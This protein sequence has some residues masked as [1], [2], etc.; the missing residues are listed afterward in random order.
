MN[1]KT[2]LLLPFI[3]IFSC[4]L[5]GQESWSLDQCIQHALKNNIQ[6]QQLDFNKEISRIDF[7]QSKRDVLPNL[8]GSARYGYNFGRSI[9]PTTYN[10]STESITTN[11]LSLNSNFNLFNGFQ[12]KNAIK[13][14]EMQYELADINKKATEEDISL[15]VFSAYLAILQTTEQLK[16]LN[17]QIKLSQDRLTQMEKMVKAGVMPKGDLYDIESQIANEE[18]NITNAENSLQQGYLN[19]YQLI[20][21]TDDGFLIE[22][23]DVE[24]P[25]AEEVQNLSS[26]AI[27]TSSLGIRP[28][29]KAAELQ[30]QIADQQIEIAEGAKYPNV[31]LNGTIGT[32]GSSLGVRNIGTETV[33]VPLF[34]LDGQTVFVPQTVPIFEDANVIQQ[35]SDNLNAYI[36]INVSVPIFNNG[37]VNSNVKRAEINAQNARLSGQIA[38]N[39]LRKEVEDAYY[40]LIA[41]AK[42]YEAAQTNVTALQNAYQQ[43]E[44]KFNL[45]VVNAFEYNSAKDRLAIGELNLQSAKYN[46]VFRLNILRFYKGEKLRIN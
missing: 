39:N 25:P 37:R 35:W 32:N 34:E 30:G 19:L 26:K 28:E 23:P 46:Y 31:S 10:F 42:S 18:L 6:L 45:G 8:N 44:K 20:E 9:D 1:L 11:G 13:A 2:L 40:N 43:A 21:Y 7:E 33:D 22:I 17:N 27:Y 38:K 5:F 3:W 12:I 15:A 36:G 4:N 29:I 24:L 41:A 14:S 16:V